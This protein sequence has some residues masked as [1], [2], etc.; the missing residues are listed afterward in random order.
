MLSM[1]VWVMLN[2]QGVIPT[3]IALVLFGFDA[4]GLVFGAYIIPDYT[5]GDYNYEH[6][7]EKRSFVHR[8]W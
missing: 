6:P 1:F 8:H 5:D 7:T 3:D 4:I 2:V